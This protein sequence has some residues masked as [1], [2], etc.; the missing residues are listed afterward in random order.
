MFTPLSFSFNRRLLLV[1]GKCVAVRAAGIRT[2]DPVSPSQP[3]VDDPNPGRVVPEVR[4]GSDGSA[5]AAVSENDVDGLRVR[6]PLP[7]KV[8]GSIPE[9]G[10][11]CGLLPLVE[12][13]SRFR[14]RRRRSRRRSSRTTFCRLTS[15]PTSAALAVLNFSRFLSVLTFLSNHRICFTVAP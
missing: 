3:V 5:S 2:H 10:H 6:L 11:G 9:L 8:L 14:C 1:D 15:I 7:E 13:L 4:A 12:E